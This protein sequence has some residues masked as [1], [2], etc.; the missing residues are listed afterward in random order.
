MTTSL[1]RRALLAAVALVASLAVAA[2]GAVSAAGS[3]A[4]LELSQ[5]KGAVS[6]KGASWH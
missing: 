2:A 4:D 5:G 1:S 6:T 3:S